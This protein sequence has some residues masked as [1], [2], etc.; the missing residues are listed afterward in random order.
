[1]GSVGFLQLS[2]L[3]QG[4]L[5]PALITREKT[6]EDRRM[7]IL[8]PIIFIALVLLFQGCKSVEYVPVETVKTEYVHRTDTLKQVDSVYTEKETIIRE[9][10]ST[11]IA[12]LGLKL[13]DNE[14]AFLILKKELEKKTS[15]E[16]KSKTDTVIIEDTIKVPYPVEKKL[17]KWQTI[18]MDIGGYFIF[19]TAFFVIVI[20]VWL[21]LKFK[22]VI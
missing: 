13:K 20:V 19:I 15:N 11:A 18:K 1:M 7:R 2:T 12:E 17:S 8:Y 5:Q 9:A 3:Q 21:I 16:Y 22:K 6:M 10:D 4:I 14:K